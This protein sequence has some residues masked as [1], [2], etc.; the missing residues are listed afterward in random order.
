MQTIYNLTRVTRER[1]LAV[2]VYIRDNFVNITI[3]GKLNDAI[4]VVWCNMG[5]GSITSIFFSR[6]VVN[7]R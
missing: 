6:E 1:N 4:D 7:Y 5:Q 2:D 3:E